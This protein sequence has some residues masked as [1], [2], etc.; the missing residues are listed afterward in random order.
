MVQ[1]QNQRGVDPRRW[2]KSGKIVEK[3]D[4]DQYL[5]KVDGG[6]RLT[7]RN[8]RFLKKIISTLADR[9]LVVREEINGGEVRDNCRRSTRLVERCKRSDGGDVQKGGDE[10]DGDTR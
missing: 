8:R 10:R 6:G 4:F 7:R 2:S 3:L 5:V 9:E 1:I